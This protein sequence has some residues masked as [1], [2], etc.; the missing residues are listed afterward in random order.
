MVEVQYQGD[1]DYNTYEIGDT[2]VLHMLRDAVVQDMRF[3][4]RRMKVVDISRQNF[5]QNW[6]CVLDTS[7]YTGIRPSEIPNPKPNTVYDIDGKKYI[8]YVNGQWYSTEAMKNVE[9]TMLAAVPIE[10]SVTYYGDV[11]R[12]SYN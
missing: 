12:N 11:V 7:N 10:G 5:L 6:E 9:N 2:G 1:T 3:I 8:Y 4:G